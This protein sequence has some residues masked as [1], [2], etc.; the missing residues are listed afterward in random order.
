MTPEAPPMPPP[1]VGDNLNMQ[2]MQQLLLFLQQQT[3]QHQ[4][5]LNPGPELDTQDMVLER[6]LR[7][8]SPVFLVEPDDVKAEYWLEKIESIFSALNYTEEQQLT[9]V[10]FRLEAASC[11]WWRT[12]VKVRTGSISIEDERMYKFTRGLRNELQ[13]K[14]LSVE[15]DSYAA[16]V[17]AAARIESGFRRLGPHPNGVVGS[18]KEPI[19]GQNPRAPQK[20][21][22]KWS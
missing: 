12:A 11:N 9:L 4:N 20:I 5:T 13:K 3:T 21:P 15:L 22:E 16:V 10:V 8:D 2:V 17:R 7:F 6:F 1:T 14:L 18:S 19:M